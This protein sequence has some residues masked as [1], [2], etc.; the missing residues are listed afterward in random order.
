MNKVAS[1]GKVIS[2]KTFKSGDMTDAEKEMGFPLGPN[3]AHAENRVLQRT[4]L[5]PGD[6]LTIKAGGREA[7]NSCKGKM[8][9]AAEE[10]GATIKYVWDGKT[11]T[12]GR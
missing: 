3:E 4:S 7:C 11:W 6:E 2:K 10:T 12:A 8:N 1:R 5:K 9:D